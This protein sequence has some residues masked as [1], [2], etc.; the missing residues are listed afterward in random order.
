MTALGNRLRAALLLKEQEVMTTRIGIDIGN[1]TTTATNG[2]RT[3]FFPS[4]YATTRRGYEGLGGVSHDR[5]HITHE[6]H[7]YIIGAGAADV[8][9]YDSLMNEAYQEHEAW[10]RYISPQSIAAMLAAIS[11]LYPHESRVEAEIGTGAPISV[12]RA[13][14]QQIADHLS[15]TYTYAAMGRPREAVITAT[16]YGEGLHALRL[17]TPEILAGRVCVHDI[18]GRT[19][20]CGFY[21]DGELKRERSYSAGIDRLLGDLAITS[22]P[23]SRWTIQREMRESR[24]AHPALRAEIER[25]IAQHLATMETKIP[26]VNAQRHVLIGGGAVYAESVIK[27]RY[28]GV[29][30]VMLGDGSPETVNAIAYLRALEA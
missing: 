7:H 23:G 14:G 3:V 8:A 9:G 29:P 20:G 17:V 2:E 1:A 28:R 18:G 19:W 16:V 21:S 15:R 10:Q 25:S 12:Y 4:F 11:A 24:K 22:D 13:H 30:I 5:H 6:D 27:A 26:L